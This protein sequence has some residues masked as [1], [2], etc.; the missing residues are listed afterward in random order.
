MN[1]DTRAAATTPPNPKGG[2]FVTT[3]WTCVV[4]ARGKS[5]EAK[6]A[7]CELCEAYW[8]P[9]FRFLRSDGRD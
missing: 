9:V 4:A 2:V 8:T 6:A 3:R 7:L 1:D 5:P